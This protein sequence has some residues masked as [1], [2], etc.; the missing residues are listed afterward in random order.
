MA[1]VVVGGA[2]G[3]YSY[4]KLKLVRLF[5]HPIFLDPRVF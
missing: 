2:V 4:E 1:L 5:F 3:G